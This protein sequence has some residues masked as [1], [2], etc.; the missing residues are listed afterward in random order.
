MSSELTRVLSVAD[1]VVIGCFLAFVMSIGFICKKMSKNSSDYFRGGGNMVWWLAGVGS[2]FAAISAWSFTGGAAKAYKD[3]IVFAVGGFIGTPI[4][5]VLLYYWAPLFRRFRVVTAMEAVF[6]RFGTGTEQMYTWVTLPLGI[7]FGAVGLNT[8]AVFISAAFHTDLVQTMLVIS[9]LVVMLATLGGQWGISI[10]AFVLGSLM[11]LTVL[12]VVVYAVYLPEI[13]GPSN[14]INV[15][16]ERH[17]NITADVNGVLVYMWIAWNIVIGVL[18]SADLRTAGKYVRLKDESHARKMVLLPLIATFTGLGI[19]IQIPAMCSAVVF[20]NL[21]EQF[22]QLKYPEEGAWIAMAMHVLPDGLLGLIVCG[23]F[24]AAFDSLDAGLNA[25]SGFFVKNVYYKFI[26]PA[27]SEQRQVIIGKLTTVGFGVLITILALAI[28][29][30]RTLNLFD[31]YQMFNA[32]ILPPLLIPVFFGMVFRRS[33]TWSA[34]STVLFG[35]SVGLITNWLYT[36]SITQFV[37]GI[38]RDL[39]VREAIDGRA[40]GVGIINTALTTLWFIVSCRFY[41]KSSAAN[42]QRVESLLVDLERPIDRKAEGCED[43][44]VAQFLVT[45]GLCLALG[46]LVMLGAVIPNP[47]HGRLAFLAVG[48]VLGL[49]GALLIMLGRSRSRRSVDSLDR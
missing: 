39:T 31:F 13:G 28:N 10:G 15:L 40:V 44:D 45:G 9:A 23:I 1:Y 48:G 35:I 30:V 14:L 47:W 43:Q 11:M 6:R 25:N 33:P 18:S 37:F 4:I 19:L 20:P 49:V 46:L 36:D 2:I 12:V 42:K 7:F 3:G 27:A 16:P 41:P 26:N 34:W 29:S 38:D 21:A 17:L 22:P 8:I 5:V 32:L 24:A